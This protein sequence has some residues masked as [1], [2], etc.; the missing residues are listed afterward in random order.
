[1]AKIS[2]MEDFKNFVSNIQNF[3]HAYIFNT[4]SVELSKKYVKEFIKMIICGHNYND[5]QYIDICYKID[6][7]EFDD[8]Y[9]V[10]SD[11]L[12]INNDDVMSLL[13]YMETKSINNSEK[14]VY[15]IYEFDKVSKIL[16]N[17]ILKFL[18]EPENNIYALLVTENI[19]QLLPTIISRCQVL[20]LSFDVDA[21][22]TEICNLMKKFLSLIISKKAKAIAYISD[23][24]DFNSIDRTY[25]FKCFEVIEKILCYNIEILC[26]VNNKNNNLFFDELH[27]FSILHLTNVLD[28]TNR[29]K[30]L[31]KNNINL[32]LLL[33]RYIIET[34]KE[35]SL[36]KE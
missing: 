5:D 15:V 30:N 13:K 29:L 22:D 31:L 26:E 20:S 36:C 7:D 14:R 25:M 3:S 28:I 11:S 2:N 35:F 33:D 21:Y 6:N 19:D 34:A 9:V 23:V 10:N 4:N 1:M 17:K 8:I 18:E 12:S 24:F 32:N 27:D 16:S